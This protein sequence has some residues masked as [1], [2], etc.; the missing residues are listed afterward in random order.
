[1]RKFNHVGI[2]TTTPK[3]GEVY[4][5]GMKLFLTDFNNSENKIEFLRF[6]ADSQMPEILK[7]YAHIAY[8]V[9]CLKSAMEGRKIVLEPFQCGEGLTCAFIEE[10]GIAIELMYFDKK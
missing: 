1:M 2:P 7:T 5:E 10:E 4:A 6:E 9:P 3:E 8:E